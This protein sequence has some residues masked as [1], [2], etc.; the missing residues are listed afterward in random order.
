MVGFMIVF[1]I[2]IVTLLLVF[3]LI[4]SIYQILLRSEKNLH[5]GLL[6]LFWA[7]IVFASLQIFHFFSGTN[8]PTLHF[9]TELLE[10][11]FLLL[12]IIGLW[13]FQRMIRVANG[14]LTHNG[15]A[16]IK[17]K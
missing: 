7:F 11:L 16:K 8:N 12:L 3:V 5:K 1:I 17:K 14:E 2:N 15:K 9:S 10:V 6:Y 4:S 13:N